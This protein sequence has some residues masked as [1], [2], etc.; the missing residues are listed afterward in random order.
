MW[1]NISEMT[2]EETERISGAF[3][4]FLWGFSC[5]VAGGLIAL[6]A[7]GVPEQAAA[8][9]LQKI[10]RNAFLRKWEKACKIIAALHGLDEYN[11]GFPEAAKT[12]TE[13]FKDP[14]F[15]R[16]ATGSV[17]MAAQ[18]IAALIAGAAEKEASENGD[19]V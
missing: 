18:C 6:K 2:A 5:D 7:E 11:P 15:I 14:E 10:V 17:K 16:I 4:D 9:A 3:N 1:K 12:F 19:C 13:M 8:V